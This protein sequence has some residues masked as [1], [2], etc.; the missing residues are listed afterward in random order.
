MAKRVLVAMSG[1]VDS[2]VAAALLKEQGYEVIGAHMK[3]WFRE[4]DEELY[5]ENVKGCCSLSAASDAK[6]VCDK[7]EIPFYVLNFKESFYNYVVKDFVDEYLH[8]RTPNPCI[9]C[10]RFMKWEEFLKKAVALECDYIATGHYARI[11]F[12]KSKDRYL[13]YRGKD[14]SKDQTY[15]LAQLTQN[16]L[17]KTLFPLGDYVKD[18]VRQM[19]K[20]RGLG[21]EQKPDSQEICFIPNDDY[22]EFL[23]KEAP[24]K[25]IQGPILDVDGNKIG[26]HKGVCHYTIG[27][28]RGLGISLGRPVY[29]VDIDPKKNA[30]IVGDTEHLYSYGLVADDVN[31]ISINSLKDSIDIECKIRYNFTEVSAKL[32]PHEKDQNKVNVRFDSPVKAITPGQGVAFYQGDLVVGGGTILD[33][34]K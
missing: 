25:I 4:E 24:D 9:A 32:E 27:Q 21:V 14:S 6:R 16:Q 22:S 7:L 11:V 34:I 28:R 29:V 5:E 33:K 1:G 30:L 31:L 18:D 10:N 12:D 20:E 17:A 23:E 13:L 26:E 2:S 8:G 19:A 15:M 3:L